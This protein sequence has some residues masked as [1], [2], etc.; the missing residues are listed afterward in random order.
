[1]K[2]ECRIVAKILDV[3]VEEVFGKKVV[4]ASSQYRVD[5]LDGLVECETPLVLDVVG[6]NGGGLGARQ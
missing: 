1:M 6:R 5:A 2:I 4:V 3:L